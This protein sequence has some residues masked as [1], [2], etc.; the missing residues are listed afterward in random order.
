MCQLSECQVVNPLKSLE[1]PIS[2]TTTFCMWEKP[3]LGV[4]KDLLYLDYV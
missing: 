3:L 1:L 4:C 2:M